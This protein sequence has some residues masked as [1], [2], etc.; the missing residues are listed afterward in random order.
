MDDFEPHQSQKKCKVKYGSFPPHSATHLSRW[1]DLIRERSKGKC[2]FQRYLQAKIA[3]E[4]AFQNPSHK[5][6]QST[7]IKTMNLF[8]KHKKTTMLLDMFLNQ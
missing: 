1:Q 4:G 3:V 7:T 2:Q 6:E 5:T 8:I